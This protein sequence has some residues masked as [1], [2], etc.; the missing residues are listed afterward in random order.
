MGNAIDRVISQLRDF[1]ES[2]IHLPSFSY[3]VALAPPLAPT[4]SDR[5][6]RSS[7]RSWNA[8]GRPFIYRSGRCQRP[9]RFVLVAHRLS[10]DHGG[11]SRLF[12]ERGAENSQVP[13]RE[14]FGVLSRRE[15]LSRFSK[16][17]VNRTFRNT[18]APYFIPSDSPFFT[19]ARE[20]SGGSPQ[21]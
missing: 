15:I 9:G 4:V 1:S 20:A 14:I 5:Y 19:R 18:D 11:G 2:A 13:P 10:R 12:L 7:S 21:L 16:H 17:L 6:F 3:D 8:P